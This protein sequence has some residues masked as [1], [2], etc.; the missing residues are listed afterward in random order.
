MSRSDQEWLACTRA[1]WSS[2]PTCNS[3]PT[4]ARMVG[5]TPRSPLLTITLTWTL[6]LT[7]RS[8]QAGEFDA[9]KTLFFSLLEDGNN[10]VDV[11][12]CNTAN[13]ERSLEHPL[14]PSANVVVARAFWRNLN[15]RPVIATDRI[16]RVRC[17]RRS[18]ASLCG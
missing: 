18:F 2:I 12:L 4:P 15:A 1:R 9:A 16:E 5:C 8:L 3:F 10:D 11:F 14:A 17:E 13:S 7:L 6:A